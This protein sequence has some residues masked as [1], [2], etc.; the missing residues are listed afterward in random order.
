MRRENG[1]RSSVAPFGPRSDADVTS[2]EQMERVIAWSRGQWSGLDR[3]GQPY[4]SATNQSRGNV[5]IGIGGLWPGFQNW[6]G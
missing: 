4:D 3:H 1:T 2:A 5:L 6:M